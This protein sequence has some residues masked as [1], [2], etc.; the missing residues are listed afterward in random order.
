MAKLLQATPSDKKTTSLIFF[1][2]RFGLFPSQFLLLSVKGCKE[3][4]KAPCMG[5]PECE[6]YEREREQ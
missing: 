3:R 2:G 5:S 4:Q 1:L 6:N